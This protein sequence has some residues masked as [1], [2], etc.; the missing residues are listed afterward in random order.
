MLFLLANEETNHW[1]VDIE[2]RL[3]DDGCF[4]PPSAAKKNADGK[5]EF[6][7]ALDDFSWDN[8]QGVFVPNISIHSDSSLYNWR[9]EHSL[10]LLAKSV[11]QGPLKDMK[12]CLTDDGF[13]RLDETAKKGADG[14]FVCTLPCVV[15]FFWDGD[16]GVF[17]LKSDARA[18]AQGNKELVCDSPNSADASSM[19]NPVPLP[20]G[21]LVAVAEHDFPGMLVKPGGVANI[22]NYREDESGTVYY[23]VSYILGGGEKGV[24]WQYVSVHEFTAS[25]RSRQKGRKDE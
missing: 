5:Y 15:G 13:L 20:V 2:R 17:A 7:N 6:V 23:D 12:R 8:D 11:L 9:R 16:R 18:Q 1:G 3:R 19:E 4:L 22:L 14:K 25:R 21:T 24:H 10:V